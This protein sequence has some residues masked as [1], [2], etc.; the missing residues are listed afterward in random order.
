MKT[1]KDPLGDI[2]RALTIVA[3]IITIVIAI[4]QFISNNMLGGEIS[5]ALFF[6]CFFIYWLI[7]AISKIS[8]YLKEINDNLKDFFNMQRGLYQPMNY[9]GQPNYNNQPNYSNQPNYAVQPNNIQ[10]NYAN[11]STGN[12]NSQQIQQ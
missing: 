10:P 9:N 5:I 3:M 8:V 7:N 1:T 6:G 11:Q 12:D 2:L 4:V